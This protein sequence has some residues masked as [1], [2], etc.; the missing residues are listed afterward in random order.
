MRLRPSS[1]VDRAWTIAVIALTVACLALS[2]GGARA[3]P[4]ETGSG[5]PATAD[6]R[7][8]PTDHI[9]IT[10]FGE[11]NLTGE[12]SVTADGS[13]SMP[14]IHSRAAS[15]FSLASARPSRSSFSSSENDRWR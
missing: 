4:V 15:L 7:L 6:Y 9:R 11:D 1:F 14:L 2:A 12:F 13:V 8:G 5:S 3:Q 10:V